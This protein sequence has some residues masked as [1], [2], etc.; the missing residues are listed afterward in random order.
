MNDVV[1]LLVGLEE[2]A[3]AL[4]PASEADAIRRPMAAWRRTMRSHRRLP[5]DHSGN[6]FARFIWKGAGL[7]DDTVV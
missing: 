4:G 7:G 5:G 1:S 3:I 6:R 2:A